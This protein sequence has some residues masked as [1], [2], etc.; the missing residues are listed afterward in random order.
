MVTMKD[1]PEAPPLW[2]VLVAILAALSD[3]MADSFTDVASTA[4]AREAVNAQAE[5]NRLL[6]AEQFWRVVVYLVCLYATEGSSI[7]EKGLTYGWNFSI[8]LCAVL[9]VVLKV[10]VFQSAVFSSGAVAVNMA[11]NFD[12]G[13]AYACDLILGMAAFSTVDAVILSTIAGVLIMTSLAAL[14]VQRKLVENSSRIVKSVRA[15]VTDGYVDS[16]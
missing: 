16:V 14:D 3:G 8:V 2:P 4:F 5:L 9:L 1:N 15:S 11:G 6:I 7:E 13:A 10:P 12:M